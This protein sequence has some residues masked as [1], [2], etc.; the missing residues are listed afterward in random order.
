MVLRILV[1]HIVKIKSSWQ[2]RRLWLPW[3]S[4]SFC[5]SVTC[6]TQGAVTPVRIG[7]LSDLSS[8]YSSIG[9]KGLI[10]ATRMAVKDVGGRVNQRP[11]EILTFDTKNKVDRAT[12]K[13]R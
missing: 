8:I 12:A 7:I 2:K 1:G 9:G 6:F 3:L 11:I 4:L 10:D 13:A 5:S